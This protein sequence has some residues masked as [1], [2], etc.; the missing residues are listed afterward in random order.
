MAFDTKPMAPASTPVLVEL[1]VSGDRTAYLSDGSKLKFP[2]GTTFAPE[3]TS[4]KACQRVTPK[5]GPTFLLPLGAT[6]ETVEAAVRRV[7][8]GV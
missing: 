6:K 3:N 7:E 4:T 8:L 1:D 2:D 5:A